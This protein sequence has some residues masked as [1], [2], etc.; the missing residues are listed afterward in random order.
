MKICDENLDLTIEYA[1]LNV[2]NI[3]MNSGIFIG[4]NQSHHWRSHTKINNGLGMMRSSTLS[5]SLNMVIDNDIM[6]TVINETRTQQSLPAEKDSLPH[7]TTLHLNNINANAL[8][9]NATLSFGDNNQRDW[10]AHNKYNNGLGILTGSNKVKQSTSI[11][12]DN[13]HIDTPIHDNGSS[14]TSASKEDVFFK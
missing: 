12:E 14:H 1:G 7:T 5:H 3:Q 13:D 4:N 10:R 6:D 11:I 2:N 9:Q 8:H